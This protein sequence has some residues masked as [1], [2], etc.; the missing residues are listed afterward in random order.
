MVVAVD[1]PLPVNHALNVPEL[2]HMAR[3]GDGAL[4]I[5]PVL[6]LGFLQELN[7]E[8]VVEVKHRHHE[9][10]LLFSHAHLDGQTPLR[11]VSAIHLLVL[12][13]AVMMMK[14]REVQMEIRTHI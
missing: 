14:V 2:L 9:P 12:V 1:G 13:V 8:R 3:D 10:L 5:E 11:N 4:L 7:E 6:L